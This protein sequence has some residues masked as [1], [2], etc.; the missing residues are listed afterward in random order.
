MSAVPY[1]FSLIDINSYLV[2]ITNIAGSESLSGSRTC[3]D[4]NHN[5]DQPCANSGL[6]CPL[7]IIRSTGKP[8]VVEHIHVD[9]KGQSIIEEVHG[10]PVFDENRAVTHIIEIV[11]DSVLHKLTDRAL[12]DSEERFR[13]ALKNSNIEVYNQDRELR[14]IWIYNPQLGFRPEE[15]IGRTDDDFLAL[16]EAAK[17]RELKKGVL[18]SGNGLRE[19]ICLTIKGKTRYFD[20]TVEPLHDENGAIVGITGASMDITQSKQAESR[21]RL[22]AQILDRL[23][24]LEGITDTIKD[25]LFMIRDF[26][27]FEAVAIRLKEGDDYPYYVANGFP[28]FFVEAERY[29]CQYNSNGQPE[30]DAEGNVLLECMCGNIIAGRTDPKY[31]FFTKGGSF[32]TN[33]TTKLLATTT[34]E[35]RQ[36]R[37]RNRCNGEG[38]ESVALIPLI[39]EA[40]PIGLLQLN[41]RRKG[42][43]TIDLIEF[44]E[45][46]GNSIGIALSQKQSANALVAEKEKAERYLNAA[47]IIMVSI[48]SGQK[49]TLINKRGCLILGYDEDELIGKRWFDICI[50]EKDRKSVQE[51]LDEITSGDSDDIRID[52]YPIVTKNGEER[53][54][55]W[56]HT[57]VRNGSNVV[58]GILISGVDIT[59]QKKAED[60]LHL[61]EERYARAQRAANIGSWD[62]NIVTGDLHWS[63]RIEPI[64]GFGEGEFGATY[65][66][67]LKC[68]HPDDRQ[69]VTDAVNAC[70]R[71]GRDYDIEHRIVWPDGTIR[72]VFETGDV[73]RNGDGEAVRMLGIVKDITIRKKAEE[74]LQRYQEELE[75]RVNE[76]TLE[77]ANSTEQLK[78]ERE[79]LERKNIALREILDQIDNEKRSIKEQITA[80]VEQLI[81]PTLRRLKESSH[82]SKART[83]EILEK[84]I[85][86][87][88]SPFIDT[89][90]HNLAKLSPREMEI[91]SLIK[92][93]FSSKDIASAL[94]SSVQTVQKQRKIIRKKLGISN[95]S[96]NLTTFLKSSEFSEKNKYNDI[97]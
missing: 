1:R 26:T 41:D 74:A 50:P 32:W 4:L 94:N 53:I 88:T 37:T 86:D 64:F 91:C 68:I 67:F 47:G 14:Y 79:A 97:K 61:S 35:D 6:A 43:F 65:E 69:L 44:F 49:I 23:N 21:L 89:L 85:A 90:K 87:I 73:V 15:I 42:M 3:Y 24:Q 52:E 96:I 7:E 22:T 70:V 20:L 55:A 60:A 16:Q 46:I 36:T 93:G 66:A 38:Y 10:Y 59:E 95:K 11:Q 5:A 48:D 31:S 51:F 81:M 56:Y 13:V 77:L 83:F 25:I 34:D 39:S 29:L 40:H 19:E 28:E 58:C 12:S 18:D 80:N 27:G 8:V 75:E 54:F 72:W 2:E 45:R 9:D 82:Q 63:D 76:R 30:R 92:N 71:N 62:W 78:I 84:D 57:L 17:L 33:S